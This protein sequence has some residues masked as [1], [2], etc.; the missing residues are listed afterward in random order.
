MTY[1]TFILLVV[2][3]RSFSDCRMPSTLTRRPK[4]RQQSLVDTTYVLP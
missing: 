1:E 4:N 3:L 2:G